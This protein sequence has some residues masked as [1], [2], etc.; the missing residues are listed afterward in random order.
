MEPTIEKNTWKRRPLRNV[1][2]LGYS[3]LNTDVIVMEASSGQKDEDLVYTKDDTL[4]NI[5]GSICALE[6][7]L[8]RY[9]HARFMTATDLL[10]FSI[11]SVCTAVTLS[12]TSLDPSNPGKCIHQ[13]C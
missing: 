10:A 12:T 2:R 9:P 1:D 13:E 6:T 5:H 3:D 4:K 8:R 11:Q 7:S